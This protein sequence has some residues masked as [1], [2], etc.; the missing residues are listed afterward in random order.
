MI[1][2]SLRCRS[3]RLAELQRV[4]SVFLLSLFP[5]S[6]GLL[7]GKKGF[8]L[9]YSCSPEIRGHTALEHRPKVFCFLLSPPATSSLKGFSGKNKRASD[10][11]KNVMMMMSGAGGAQAVRQDSTD[12]RTSSE[13]PPNTHTHTHTQTRLTNGAAGKQKFKKIIT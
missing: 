9:L 8:S 2:D 6:C 12:M 7:K 5:P 11:S 3:P 4:S 1:E 10:Y 13:A